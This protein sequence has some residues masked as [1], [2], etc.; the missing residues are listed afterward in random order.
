[1]PDYRDNFNSIKVRLEPRINHNTY[2]KFPNFN[3][4]KVRLELP[5][6]TARATAMVD[7]NSIK[8]RLEPSLSLTNMLILVISIP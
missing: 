1:M 7:F 4:I 6:A 8:V 5:F 2:I 3:S